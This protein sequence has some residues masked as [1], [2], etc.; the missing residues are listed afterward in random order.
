MVAALGRAEVESMLADEKG[1]TITCG[2]CNEVYSLNE[3]EL[4]GLLA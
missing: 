1:A 2:F 3:E 4:R